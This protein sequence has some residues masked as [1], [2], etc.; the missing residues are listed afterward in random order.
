MLTDHNQISNSNYK[1]IFYLNYYRR[2][3][4]RKNESDFTFRISFL[5]KT[6]L[7]TNEDNYGKLI[8]NLLNILSLWLD[9]T[10]FDLYVYVYKI[11][12][13]FTLFI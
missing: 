13:I 6:L 2:E 12:K 5:K 9:H 7:V 8:L 11:F 4:C 10:V 3:F 1:R